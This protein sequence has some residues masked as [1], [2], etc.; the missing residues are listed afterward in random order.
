MTIRFLAA[1]VLGLVQTAYAGTP[2]PGA[3]AACVKYVQGLPSEIET[4]FLMVPEDWDHPT[5]SPQIPVFFYA[6]GLKTEK[7]FIAYF[8][9]GPGGATHG[10][11]T[12]LKSKVPL[13]A[14]VPFLYID[15]R[16]TGC[17]GSYPNVPVT[18]E[19]GKRLALYG[20]RNIVRDAE[21]VRKHLLGDQPWGIFGQSFG[22]YIVHRY[23]ATFPKSLNLAVVHGSS[24][25]KN[26]IRW[27]ET[28]LMAQHRVSQEYLK[29]Y[30]GDADILKSARAQVPEDYCQGNKTIQVCG[31]ALLDNLAWSPITYPGRWPLLHQTLARLLKSDG[32]LDLAYLET[33]IP[34]Q[35]TSEESVTDFMVA[36]IPGREVPGGLLN[37]WSCKKAV[38]R[39]KR[40]G[41][42][43]QSWF[44]SECRTALAAKATYDS[45][46]KKLLKDDMIELSD[47]RKS[48]KKNPGLKFHLFSGEFDTFIARESY[49]E[50]VKALSKFSNFS[51]K[52]ILNIG[53]DWL[54]GPEVWSAL[55]S[56]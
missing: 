4:D 35:V 43:S 40:R 19:S 45:F 15:Q 53:H 38:P 14:G 49:V 30:P 1:A 27:V 41:V 3:S 56:Y 11:Y 50:E 34:N 5:T 55:K 52:N 8:N 20:T 23:I 33:L 24:L 21:A 16:G 18:L 12:Y 42:D 51:F 32:K 25:M 17:S 54:N 37:T 44:Y 9:G 31:A 22:G 13:S 6:P 36:V 39:M 10:V 26:G 28:R 2:P 46:L 47:V 48:L 7:K 29:I